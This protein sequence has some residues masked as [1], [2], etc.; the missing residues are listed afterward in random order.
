MIW[1][2]LWWQFVDKKNIL[3]TYKKNS[4]I[5]AALSVFMYIAIF[6]KMNYKV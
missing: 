5:F 6:L 2:I 3:K 4:L 1:Y